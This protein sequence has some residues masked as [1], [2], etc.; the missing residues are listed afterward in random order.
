MLTVMKLKTG[1]N[2]LVISGKYRGRKGKI[3]KALPKQGKIVVEGMNLQKKHKRP[4]RQGEKG[5]VVE[6][7]APFRAS[8]AKLVCAKCS[9]ATRVGYK[10]VD[11]KK[12]RICK[13]C[14][15]ET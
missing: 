1:D 8:S 15:E 12:Y 2:I 3:S 7:A 10:I 6:I 14:G 5:Q 4:R 13:K 11:G 9:K